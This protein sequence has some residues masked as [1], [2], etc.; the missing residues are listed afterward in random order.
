MHSA[1]YYPKN[2][3]C[4]IHSRDLKLRC[5]RGTFMWFKIGNDPL[6]GMILIGIATFF[7]LYSL[8]SVFDFKISALT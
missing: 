8:T 2:T 7:L 4:V 5:S 3:K 6:Y 1:F